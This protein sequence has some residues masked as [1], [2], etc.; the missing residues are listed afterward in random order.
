MS[1]DLPTGASA[2]L[3]T[4]ERIS[5]APKTLDELTKLL[6]S[7][8]SSMS[9]EDF[10][11]IMSRILE[12]KDRISGKIP[13]TIDIHDSIVVER[14]NGGVIKRETAAIESALR[15]EKA[16]KIAAETAA[17]QAPAQQAAKNGSREAVA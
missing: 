12:Q 6:E 1:K 11:A 14:D 15:R 13:A 7:K 10:K 4:S 17:I 9:D 5:V 3:D 8:K 16:R 2:A